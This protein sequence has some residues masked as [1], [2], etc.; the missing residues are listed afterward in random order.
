MGRLYP[1]VGAADVSSFIG[2]VYAGVGVAD[3]GG[4]IDG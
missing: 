4:F 1:G 2:R 3:V